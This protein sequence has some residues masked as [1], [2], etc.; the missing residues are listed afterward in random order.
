MIEKTG[1]RRGRPRDERAHEA[2]LEATR[3]LLLE[4][5][6]PALTIDA[7][8]ARARTAKTTIYRRWTSKGELV[9]EAAAAR[10]EIGVVP[11]TGSTRGDLAVAVRQLIT[12]FSDPLVSIVMLA[13]IADLDDEPTLGRRFRDEIVFPWRSSAANA[14][15]R[16]RDRGDL[17]LGSEIAFLLDVIVGTVFQRTV[18][19]P[20]PTDGL[21]PAIVRLVLGD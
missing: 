17:P 15:E 19:F 7:V 16:A 10:L 6:Y 18:I 5:G 4:R 1:S 2:I 14:L 12:T 8:A 11:D 13:V 20:Q 3:E 21:E 9:L